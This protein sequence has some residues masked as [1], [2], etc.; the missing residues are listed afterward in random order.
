MSEVT[1]KQ[2]MTPA[3]VDQ[4]RGDGAWGLSPVYAAISIERLIA[5]L[6]AARGEG[7]RE[8]AEI[9][10]KLAPKPFH[11]FVPANEVA[12]AIRADAESSKGVGNG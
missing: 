11:F 6:D 3:E 8:A 5:T 4:L 9:A 1:P 7:M 12:A 2:P 10:D